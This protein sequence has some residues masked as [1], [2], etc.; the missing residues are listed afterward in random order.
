M[1]AEFALIIIVFVYTIFFYIPGSES[2]SFCYLDAIHILSDKIITN[3][4]P[5]FILLSLNRTYRDQIMIIRNI[6]A[7]H[8]S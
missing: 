7:F 8:I 2:F 6:I 4:V 3:G 1:H 5:V